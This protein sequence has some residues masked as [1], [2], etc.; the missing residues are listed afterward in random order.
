MKKVKLAFWLILLVL[1]VVIGWQNRPF[2]L[3]KRGVDIDF[4][5]GNY[6]IPELQIGLYFL[7]FFLAG[8]VIAYFGSLSERFVSRKTIRKINN[9]L[10]SANKKNA[11]LEASLASLQTAE[12]NVE[13]SISPEVANDPETSAT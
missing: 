4:L 7:I 9:E 1:F 3:E 13:S 2:F 11:E 12:T 8:L 6:H 10:K 5:I